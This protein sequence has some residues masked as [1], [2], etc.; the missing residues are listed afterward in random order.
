MLISNKF[1]LLLSKIRIAQCNKKKKL[2]LKIFSIDLILLDLL[3]KN[4]VIYGYNKK[5]DI[6]I[7]F[8]RY[9]LRGFGMVDSVAFLY[10]ILT[11]KQLKTLIILNPYYSYLILTF[12]GISI[13]SKSNLVDYGGILIAKL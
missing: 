7:I 6:C 5:K 4:G 1:K 10:P 11:K 8:L 12:K 2:K 13:C 9:S 3:W